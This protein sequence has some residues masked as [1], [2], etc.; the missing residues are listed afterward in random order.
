LKIEWA[1]SSTPMLTLALSGA[2]RETKSYEMSAI[3]A[4]NEWAVEILTSTRVS[5]RVQKSESAITLM[6]SPS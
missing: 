2:R 1:T 6:V 5:Q 3:Y 4:I